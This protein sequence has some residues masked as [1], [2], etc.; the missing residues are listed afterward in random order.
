[1]GYELYSTPLVG[2]AKQQFIE[3]FESTESF[4]YTFL[5]NFNYSKYWLSQSYVSA[6]NKTLVFGV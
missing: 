4:V 5:N 6:L 1:M 2:I 3:C